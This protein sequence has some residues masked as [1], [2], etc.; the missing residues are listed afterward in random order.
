MI[1]VADLLASTEVDVLCPPTVGLGFRE[2]GKRPAITEK[3]MILD[4]NVYNV[5]IKVSV[6]VIERVNSGPR[7]RILRGNG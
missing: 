5:L 6:V 2:L 3:G 7:V 1:V 4:L